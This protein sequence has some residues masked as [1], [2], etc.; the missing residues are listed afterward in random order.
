ME[1]RKAGRKKKGIKEGGNERRLVRCKAK[2]RRM[3]KEPRN[4][5]GSERRE[6]EGSRE[7]GEGKGNEGSHR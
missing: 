6:R 1:D 7:E 4:K 5:E 3:D 2:E